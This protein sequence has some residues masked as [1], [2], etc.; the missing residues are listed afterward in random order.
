MTRKLAVTAF[1]FGLMLGFVSP[2]YAQA[3]PQNTL[4]W[5]DNCNA[6]GCVE[7]GFDVNRKLLTF[8]GTTTTGSAT[9]NWTSGVPVAQLVANTIITTPNFPLG[10]LVVSVSGNNV[11]MSNPATAS[12]PGQ[13][14]IAGVPTA[15]ASAACVLDPAL[16][17][18]LTAV[19]QNVITYVD[20]AV[21]QGA[22]HCYTVDAFNT[23]TSAP[24]NVAGRTVPFIVPLA[25]STLNAGP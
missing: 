20:T 23:G 19:G 16:M 7:F 18:K 8:T 4:T 24:S 17:P 13:L 6:P 3:A 22:T 1:L 12:G 11:V 14:L 21:T 2:A 5:V 25:P 10:T 9:V 15:N